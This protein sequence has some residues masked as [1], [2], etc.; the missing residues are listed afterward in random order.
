MYNHK[1]EKDIRCPLEY[2]MELFGGKW[3]TRII[4]VLSIKKKLRYGELKKEL[5]NITDTVLAATLKE[6]SDSG[7]VIRQQ[8]NEIPPRVEYSL[9]EKGESVLPILMEICKWTGAYCNDTLESSCTCK[10]C[11]YIADR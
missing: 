6:L 9:S 4:C 2:G 1:T 3:K 11:D 7:M 5:T 10:K 8:Y